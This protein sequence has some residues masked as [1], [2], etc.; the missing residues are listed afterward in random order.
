M[1]GVHC[2]HALMNLALLVQ[3][4]LCSFRYHK[5]EGVFVPHSPPHVDM[6][7]LSENDMSVGCLL[8][9]SSPT[10]STPLTRPW[11]ATSLEKPSRTCSS[12]FRLAALG[13]ATTSVCHVFPFQHIHLSQPVFSDLFLVP[14]TLGSFCFQSTQHQQEGHVPV[15]HQAYLSP[16]HITMIARVLG[17][18]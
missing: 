14:H 4:S 16:L 3:G 17:W 7:C 9:L 11:A 15:F 6:P 12:S 2:V 10:R 1:V 18:Q 5:T 8:L 13:V